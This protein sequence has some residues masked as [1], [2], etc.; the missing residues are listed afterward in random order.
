MGRGR[1]IAVAVT[2]ALLLFVVWSLVEARLVFVDESIVSSPDLPA[3]LDGTRIAFAS[4]IHAGSL[5]G[6]ARMQAT[7]DQLQALDGDLIILGGDFGGGGRYGYEWFYPAAA[8]LHA[9][10]GVYAV[11]GNHEGGGGRARAIGDLQRAGITLLL[12]DNLRV[13]EGGAGL[14][15]AG[16]D[17]HITGTPD[18]DSAAEGISPSEFAILLSHNADAL[19]EGL[20]RVPGAFD[21]AL[22]GHNHGGQITVFGLWAPVLPSQYGQR[23]RGGWQQ[24]DGV[25]LLVSR[26]AGVFV[27]PMRFF[28][29]AQIHVITLRRGPASVKP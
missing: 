8:R 23:F 24:I 20:P 19:P 4:D 22:S 26:G 15:L 6:Q 1:K 13:S 9:P 28:A 25:P 16:L 7:L 18:I 11:L 27:V 10:L 17:D 21:L 14:R 5:L 3:D 29:P 2:L 12:N